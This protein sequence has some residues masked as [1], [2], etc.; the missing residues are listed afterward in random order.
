MAGVRRKHDLEKASCPSLSDMS[1]V[2]R[3]SDGQKI[4]I[5][6]TGP[7]LPRI[8]TKGGCAPP[9]SRNSG[10]FKQTGIAIQQTKTVLY[11]TLAACCISLS[12][13]PNWTSGAHLA[14]P[15][16]RNQHP[17]APPRM[18]FWRPPS[19]NSKAKECTVVYCRS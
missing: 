16:R 3:F 1:H 8:R 18:T 12:T 6:K 15:Q 2:A 7:I 19:R 14:T 4:G 17:P 9:N 13:T 10:F 11:C 5:C